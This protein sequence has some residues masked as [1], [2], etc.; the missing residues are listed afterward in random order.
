[1]REIKFRAWDEKNKV[2]INAI[3]VGLGKVYG[4]T[5]TFKPSKKLE[6]V[7]LMQYTGLKDNKNNKEIYEGDIVKAN[8][9][10]VVSI[11]KVVYIDDWA[12][13][14][15]EFTIGNIGRY[16]CYED[17]EVIGNIY[18]NPELLDKD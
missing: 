9:N 18:E 17:D 2:M 14:Q 15:T 4:M 11:G 12:M 6:D 1:M 7:I 16:S 8:I 5:K 10:N 3:F 13:F